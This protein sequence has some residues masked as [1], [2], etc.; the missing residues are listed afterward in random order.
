VPYLLAL[1]RQ[2]TSI[3]NILYKHNVYKTFSLN[4][5]YQMVDLK[6]GADVTTDELVSFFQLIA[7][8]TAQEKAI[9]HDLPDQFRRTILHLK[10]ANLLSNALQKIINHRSWTDAQR[11]EISSLISQLLVELDPKKGIITTEVYEEYGISHYRPLLAKEKEIL[12]KTDYLTLDRFA[13]LSRILPH[14]FKSP[15]LRSN[16]ESI[17]RRLQ[18]A[19]K[20]EQITL[21][22]DIHIDN[23]LHKFRELLQLQQSI[24]T[25]EKEIL[26]EL[27]TYETKTSIASDILQLRTLSERFLEETR[28]LKKIQRRFKDEF[29]LPFE[30]YH[31]QKITSLDLINN[32][33][34]QKPQKWYHALGFKRPKIN[35]KEVLLEYNTMTTPEEKMEFISNL[36]FIPQFLEEKVRNFIQKI[37][38]SITQ[39]MRSTRKNFER[40]LWEKRF[41]PLTGAYTKPLFFE[42]FQKLS[43]QYG[44]TKQQFSL[45]VFDIDHFKHFNDNYG[46]GVGDK[47][48]QGMAKTVM[49]HIRKTDLFIRYGGEEFILLLP[50][51]N[52]DHALVIANKLRELLPI[53]NPQPLNPKTQMPI[54]TSIGVATFPDDC[55]NNPSPQELFDK[56]DKALYTAKESG[57]N[58]VVSA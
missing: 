37:K 35:L 38:P 43:F 28:Q 33:L 16:V 31:D 15:L 55:K 34:N 39:E 18:L 5:P 25:Q 47:V 23:L 17:R 49:R 21:T 3:S 1:Q 12:Y 58:Q 29:Y 40:L 22:I 9:I 20:R 54:T 11:A 45:L 44:R 30:K 53:E 52:K 14:G 27:R 4:L 42:E 57:R 50:N 56:A 7:T 46:H 2:L 6:S 41:D 32:L 13:H 19:H 51:T 36:E 8:L 26:I 24:L 10:K 48:L